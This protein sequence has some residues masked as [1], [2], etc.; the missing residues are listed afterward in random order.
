MSLEKKAML[1]KAT[2][3]RFH[4]SEKDKTAIEEIS[5]KFN[6]DPKMLK[7]RKNTLLKEHIIGI[8]KKFIG[9]LLIF[10]ISLIIIFNYKKKDYYE[11]NNSNYHY[12]ISTNLL[13][14]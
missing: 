3:H 11:K 10:K 8:N 7:L 13:L 2:V 9:F 6:V 4:F 14:Q 1:V 12:I 5:Q